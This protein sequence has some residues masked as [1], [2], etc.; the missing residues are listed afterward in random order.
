[1]KTLHRNEEDQEL[2]DH[3]TE[4]KFKNA[5]KEINKEIVKL[6]DAVLNNRR[7]NANAA[8]SVIESQLALL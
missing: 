7:D 6:K 1:M 2:H 3:H 8:I 4:E 5:L